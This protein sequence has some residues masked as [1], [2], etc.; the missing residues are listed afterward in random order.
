MAGQQRFK[1]LNKPC[2]LLIVIAGMERFAFKGVASNLVIYL[3]D[4]VKMSN[5]SAAKTV[6]SWCGFTSIMPLLVAPLADSLW[7][8]YS[9][10]LASSFFYI[11]GLAAL[12]SSTFNW[13]SPVHI[14]KNT[15][16]FFMFWSLCLISLGQGGYNPSLQAFGADQ[17][18]EEID[19]PSCN[20]QTDQKRKK[21]KRTLFFTW[22][23]FGICSGSLLGVSIMSYIQ[24]TLGWS[25]GFAVPT[26]V[27]VSSIVLFSYGTKFYAYNPAKVILDNPNPFESMVHC[28]K[29]VMSRV[30]KCG[31]S[32]SNRKIELEM[33][34]N[35]LSSQKLVG[36]KEFNDE[37]SSASITL[38]DHVKVTLRLL[39]IWTMLLM[40][41][42]IFQQPATF[43][44]KQGMTMRRNIGIKF[45]I[46]PATLQGAIT[47]SI[48]LLMPFYDKILVPFT[49]IITRN[50]RGISVMQ[51]MGVGMVLSIIAMII[52]ALVE[53][54][55]L[56]TPSLS[57]FWLL[58]QYILLGISDIF[59]VVGMQEFF[60]GEVPIKMKTMGIALYTSVFGVGSFLSALMISVIEII[61]T[62]GGNQSWFSD[63]MTKARLDKYYWLLAIS[64]TIS[65]LV[66]V[67][68]CRFHKSRSDLDNEDSI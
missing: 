1:G 42:V 19:L 17:L 2:I 41:A 13:A 27:M 65:L 66:Y 7:D 54:K 40:F 12:T 46:P 36:I 56:R 59:T 29:V 61:T 30:C 43:F 21:S 35:E 14:S 5:S 58:P 20:N 34:E 10:I 24:D 3:T 32:E 53:E 45:K 33:Q 63:D 62:R 31:I 47:I 25:L 67:I 51:R 57:I 22:W 11:L 50:E 49:R 37:N 64:S 44:T 38:L 4:V 60:Y 18:G 52:A 9:T 23:Y 8:H 28:L 16:T 55:R 26:L 68:L 15:S 48:I 6:N 39:P